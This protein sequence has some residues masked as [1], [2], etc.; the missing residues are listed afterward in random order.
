MSNKNAL[1]GMLDCKQDSTELSTS[2]SETK[3]RCSTRQN[4]I[5]SNETKEFS[6]FNDKYYITKELGEGSTASVY[7]CE[8]IRDSS[9]KVALKILK[10][11][12]L[13]KDKKNADSLVNEIAILTSCDHK[14]II[15]LIEYGYEGVIHF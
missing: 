5:D 4:S 13:K 12:Y 3:T 8:S 15:K 1:K 7:L 9:K 14:N 6:I 11:E 10:K 2:S